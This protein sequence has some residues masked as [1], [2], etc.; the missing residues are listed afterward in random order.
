MVR[1]VYTLVQLV[2]FSPVAVHQLYHQHS[3]IWDV[4]KQ[5]VGIQ[6]FTHYKKP[7]L[8]FSVWTLGLYFGGML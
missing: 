8:G 6:Y 1:D 2:H 5:H 3:Q 7:L 4:M